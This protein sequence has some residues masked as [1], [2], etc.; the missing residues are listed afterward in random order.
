MHLIANLRNLCCLNYCRHTT[1]ND[2]H[3]QIAIR[4]IS[5][6]SLERKNNYHY[7]I[8]HSSWLWCW[9]IQIFFNFICTI[10]DLY[11][12]VYVHV[13]LYYLFLIIQL[14]TKKTDDSVPGT[15]FSLLHMA[16]HLISYFSTN[17]IYL[18]QRKL[19][20]CVQEIWS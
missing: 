19:Y 8:S 14:C 20:G 11:L 6:V 5:I 9:L 7:H 15:D 3:G 17:I 16:W 13:L 10:F 4:C 12:N 18:L 2:N 1:I